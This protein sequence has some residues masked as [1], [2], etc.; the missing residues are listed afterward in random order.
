MTEKRNRDSVRL[1]EAGQQRFLKAKAE[2]YDEDNKPY[3]FK[4]VYLKSGVSEKTVRRFLNREQPVSR[5][6]AIRIA[7]ALK[8]ELNDDDIDKIEKNFLQ[9]INSDSI[10]SI[11]WTEIC[12]KML[13]PQRRLSSN[14]LLHADENSKFEREQIYVP[15]ALIER[16]KPDRREEGVNPE[17]GTRLYEPN[18]EEKQR[19]EHEAF[20]KQILASGEGKTQ[21]KQIALIGEPG[22]GKTTLLQ[23]IADWI[24]EQNLGLPIW[25]SLADLGQ[26][27]IYEY[28]FSTW[29]TPAAFPVSTTIAEPDLKQQIAQ[30]KVWLLLDG[31]DEF[32][33]AGIQA[34]QAIANQLRGWVPPSRVILTCR[35]NVWEADKNALADFETY[36]L[37]DFDYPQQVHQFIDN[38]FSN[39]DFAEKK[40]RVKAELESPEKARLRDL[41]QNPLRLTLLCA[42]WQSQEGNLPET[43]AGLYAQFVEQFYKWK[44]DRFP[45]SYQEKRLL[46]EA[47]GRLAV[48]DIDTGNTRFRLRESFIREAIGDDSLFEK[49]LQLGWLNNVGIAAE[50]TEERVY[51]FF[52]A[53]FEEY[54]AAL[55]IDDWD[56]FVPRNHVDKP[57]EGKKYQIF[58]PQWKEVILTWLGREDV[59]KEEKEKF[60]NALVEFE[61][62]CWAF[63]WYRAYFLAAVGIAEFKN[64]S[65]A[66]EIVKTIIR[67]GFGYFDQETEQWMTFLEPIEKVARAILPE[68]DRKRAIAAL[69]ELT[70]TAQDEDTR[71]RAVQS[72]GQIGQGN[73]IV[74]AALIELIRTAQDEDTRRRAVQS[75]EQ[76]GQGNPIAIAALI[77]LIRTAQHE[78]IR[79]QAVQSLEQIGQGNPIAIAALIELIRTAQHEYIRLQAARI[80]LQIDPDHSEAITALIEL[81]RTA[82]D[83]TTL[84]EA[85][86]SLEQIGRGNPEAI[87]AL[88][89]LIRTAQ[90]QYTRRR[91]ARI[92]LRIDPDNPEAITALI[93]LT[94]TAQ[95]QT[96]FIEAVK[97]LRSLGKLDVGNPEAITAL[98]KLIRTVQDEGIRTEAAENLGYIDPGN[99]I[100]IA[101]LIELTRTAQHKNTPIQATESLGKIGKGNPEVIATLIELTRT[102]QDEST[103]GRA[104][105]S[106]GKIG[107]GNP[108]V[109]AA[110][111]ELI[112]T[113]QHKYTRSQAL[114][115]LGKIGQGNPEAIAALVELTRTAQPESARIEVAE[116]LWKIDPGNPEIIL[117]LIELIGTSQDKDI[118][119]QAANSLE[120]IDPGNPEVIAALVELIRTAQNE[121]ICRQAAESLEKID[122][123]NPEVIAA[124]VELIR[125]A[126]DNDIRRQAANSLEAIVQEPQMAM[127]VSTLQDNLSNETYKNDFDRFKDCH[128]ILWKCAQN[129]PYPEFYQAWHNPP[130]TPHPEVP[131]TTAVGYTPTVQTLENQ[132]TDICNQLNHSSCLC[133]NAQTLADMTNTA[134][135]AQELCNQ[136]FLKLSLHEIPAVT[137]APQ[138]KRHLIPLRKQTPNLALILHNGNPEPSLLKFCRQITDILPI[139]WITDSPL[140]PPLRGFLPQQHNLHSAIQAWLE[141]IGN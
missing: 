106:L 71:R 61:D 21:G 79:L 70:R 19:F 62:N 29:L 100:A 23:T 103:R 1:N 46:N 67:W 101:T 73:P 5:D 41:I 20:L 64:G 91:V 35:L 42:S 121:Y 74:I 43:K 15:L 10:S 137:N 55:A 28:L 135:I 75:L 38:W 72:L 87:K 78:Y 31:V 111:I 69:V 57:V 51:A 47:L 65:M 95:D 133:I 26:K 141:E 124:L 27:E 120:K 17:A 37:L 112:R 4:D 56:Y 25:I 77:E 9:Q 2:L 129:L 132:I 22:A 89:G 92:L 63:Y 119:R 93:G 128:E 6:S 32:A 13:E 34:L 136:I 125:T 40:E 85:A 3:T 102:A 116:S 18:Y 140:E 82:Q 110:L 114:Q 16:R 81:I 113:A 122:P 33:T 59:K 12:N 44:C 123:G 115:S 14:L 7:N 117:A 8:I 60:I 80:L 68:T 86:T 88:I 83:Q 99:P 50:A 11:N 24:L 76:I 127:V 84:I 90:D 52:H 107:Q 109:I 126:Q 30:G 97:S 130:I 105:E 58:E 104:T 138:L 108:K 139:A 39:S 53:S 118:R 98:I 45:I 96:T 134:E 66:D 54:F 131:E 49:A 48:Q 36:R 94:C